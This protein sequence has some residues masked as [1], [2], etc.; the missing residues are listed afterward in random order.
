MPSSNLIQI[1]INY[2]GHDSSAALSLGN[3]IVAATEQERYDLS[4]HSRNFPLDAIKSCLKKYK[5]KISDIDNLILTT[6]FKVAVDEFYLKPALKNKD[7]LFK[8]IKEIKTVKKYLE[9]ENEVRKKLNFK[10]N[11]ITH[12]HHLCH[13]ASA[14][15]PSKFKKS[16]ILSLDGV[17][18]FE[19]GKLAIGNNGKIKLCEF[20][21]NYPNSLGLIYSAVTYFLGWKHHCDEGIIMGLAPYGNKNKKIP[22]KKFTYIDLF[23]KIIPKT[24]YLGFKINKDWIAFHLKRDV[25]ISEKFKFFFGKKREPNEKITQHHKNIAAALQF[26]LEEIV[27]HNLKKIKKKYQINYLCIAGGVGLNCSL[28]GK[29]H[30]SK[31]FK[32]IFVQPAAGDSGLALGGL[33]LS[34]K[35]NINQ[36]KKLNKEFNN[37]L[38]SKFTDN[39]IKRT[40]ISKKLKYTKPLNIYKSVAKLIKDG[41]I[42]AWFQGSSEFGPRALGNRS[43]LCKPYPANMKDYLNKRV[44]FREYFRPFAPAVLEEKFKEYFDLRQTSPH[45]LIACKVKKN[46]FK[47][48]PAVVH[49]D[50]SC[51][52]QTVSKQTNLR[53]YNLIKEFYALTSIPILLNTSFNI[54]GQP[55][56]N[57]PDQALST[58]KST[59]I[60]V[61]VIG[62]YVI[63]K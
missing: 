21:A 38:G 55:M 62:D 11:I 7:N 12:D 40:I 57:T 49:V 25:W 63:S 6:N 19:T 52:V 39:E 32:K 14:Y 31:L 22:G 45:M 56:V 54:K 51:R 50:N 61:L 29:I 2:G 1:S 27:L 34:I 36:N 23:R 24:K 43:I 42:I 33:Y 58:F 53:F 5:L 37:Y 30:D 35:N 41:K 60:D 48:I 4:K 47:K 10:G 18:Q 13:L 9:I 28:N 17:G 8:L 59:N 15:F 46:K 16:I 44:K 3:K 20:E 26:R